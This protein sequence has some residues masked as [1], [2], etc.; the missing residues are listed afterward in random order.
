MSNEPTPSMPAPAATQKFE[1][2]AA[3]ADA[4]DAKIF[5][6]TEFGRRRIMSFA[7]RVMLG[8]IRL[9]SFAKA[10]VRK[11]RQRRPSP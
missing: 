3:A 5:Q 1:R 9:S 10:F 11:L 7:M 6:R 8:I 4:N 2:K